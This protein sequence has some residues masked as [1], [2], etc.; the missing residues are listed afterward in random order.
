MRNSV[1]ETVISMSYT[2]KVSWDDAPDWAVTLRFGQL[3]QDYFWFGD[4][5][6][7]EI[8]M[9]DVRLQ[10][11][12]A[13]PVSKAVLKN[14]ALVDSR[15]TPKNPAATLAV[16]HQIGES[17]EYRPDQLK[18]DQEG[19][20]YSNEQMAFALGLS[21]STIVKRRAGDVSMGLEVFYAVQYLKIAQVAGKIN[22]NSSGEVA[23]ATGKQT[24]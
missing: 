6:G 11:S 2:S 24:T 5:S 4:E 18:A 16:S 9:V 19:L 10:S 7:D 20:G 15:H 23:C 14:Y 8:I 13:K 12:Y 21:V 3:S 22:S 17:F 1:R